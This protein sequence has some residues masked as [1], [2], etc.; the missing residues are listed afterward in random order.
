VPGDVAV[1][2]RLA[3][4]LALADD[5]LVL[6]HRH[7]EWTG[8]APH[9]E[10]D[11][12]FSSIAQDEMAH[13]R[14]LYELAGGLTNESEDDLAFG[15][16]P[17]EYRN[18]VLCERPNG[19]WGYTVARQYLYDTADAVRLE[20]LAGSSWNELADLAKLMQME[21]TYHLDHG[22]AW[23]DR[24]AVGP[25]EAR[26][27]FAAGLAKAMGEAVA[28][29]EPLPGESELVDQAVLPRPSEELLSDWLRT[30]G[31]TLEAA[32]LDYVLEHH[33]PLGGEMVPTSSGEIQAE[34]E[35]LQAPGLVRRDGVW[36]HE[37]RFE[38]AGGRHGRHSEDFTALW[39]EM[40]QLHRAHPGATW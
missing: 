35:Q 29:F 25:L 10:E 16:R 9:L 2:P 30:L 24:L 38:G 32:S 20:A 13:A 37:G 5:E 26:N 19:D 27:R 39:E 23:F 1:D 40:T 34:A 15:R 22:R 18:A 17:E 28:L 11:L 8:W 31:E 4:L 36:M 6:G 21:E 7:A 12:A 14:L 33:G 3:L